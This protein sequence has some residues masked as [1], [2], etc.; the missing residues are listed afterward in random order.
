MSK[1]F[2]ALSG[3]AYAPGQEPGTLERVIYTLAPY[4]DEAAALAAFAIAFI[5]IRGARKRIAAR[6]EARAGGA[7]GQPKGRRRIET[8]AARAAFAKRQEEAERARAEVA[9]RVTQGG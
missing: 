1:E 9:G 4:A 6:R 7:G 5:V 3:H 2:S 8:E